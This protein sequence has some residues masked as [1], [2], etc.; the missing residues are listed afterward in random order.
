MTDKV[1]AGQNNDPEY[2]AYRAWIASDPFLVSLRDAFKEGWEVGVAEQQAEIE[3][4]REALEGIA[5]LER[6]CDDP[7]CPS[8][9][10]RAALD[11]AEEER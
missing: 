1:E 5:S 9:I 8:E 6:P 10:A 2:L 11:G 7:Q 3:R 4:L